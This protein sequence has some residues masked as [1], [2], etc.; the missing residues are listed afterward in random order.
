MT[1]LYKIQLLLAQ[2]LFAWN[3]KR[4]YGSLFQLGLIEV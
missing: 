2:I 1:V 3:E 4:T